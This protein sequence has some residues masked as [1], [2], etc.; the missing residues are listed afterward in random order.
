MC[1]ISGWFVSSLL[2]EKLKPQAEHFTATQRHRGPDSTGYFH[3]QKK[4][5]FLGHNRLS[6]IDLSDAAK[7]PMFSDSNHV[8]VLNGEIYNYQEL[9]VELTSKGH[10]FDSASDSEV[11]L[12]AYLEWGVHFTQKL[13]GMYSIAIWDEN[14]ETLHLFRDPLGIKPLY[15]WQMPNQAGIAFASELKSFLSINTFSPEVLDSSLSQYIEFGHSIDAT[16]TIFK[17]VYKLQPGHRLE[18]KQHKASDQIC[19]YEPELQGDNTQSK[20]DFEESL[21]STLSQVVK[22]HLIADVPVGLLLSGGLDSSLIASIAAQHTK[23]HTFSMG[24]SDSNID[25][26]PFAKMV[27][28]H[29]QSVHTEILISPEEILQQLET[30]PA[31]FD[32]IFS[33]WGMVSTKLLYSKCQDHDI[34]VV[35]VGEGSDELF[36]GYGIF[37]K[38]LSLAKLPKEMALFELYRQ[39]S[40]RRYGKNYG[41]FRAIMKS[42]LSQC[43]NDLFSAIRLFETRN[44]LPNNFIMK[45]DKASMATSIEARTPFLDS[46]VANI[47]LQIPRPMLIKENDEKLI[48]KSMAERYKLLPDDIIQRR[49]FGTGIAA[50]WLEDSPSFRQFAK[51]RILAP[52]SWV[53]RLDLRDAMERYFNDG[54][55]GYKFPKSISLFG[56]LAWRLL[57]LSL[58]SNSLGIKA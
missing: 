50:N 28:D 18:I 47:S 29:I 5:V 1:G 7:Q 38:S 43:N 49:K 11:A 56:N 27:S 14:I 25:E 17:G 37:K 13:H 46:R 58:W 41:K 53:D 35:L 8:M 24:F 15:Y 19:F 57:I 4:P 31:H 6:I 3:S 42:Y 16:H 12:K 10:T 20:T 52:D 32:D 51:E 22:E 21:Y 33:D 30:L 45:V 55:I 40:G 23:V 36:G 39:Y 44:Q 2:S 26:R 48:L 9:K 34:K 54:Q